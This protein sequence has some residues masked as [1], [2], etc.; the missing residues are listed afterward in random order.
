MF[1]TPNVRFPGRALLGLVLLLAV[2]AALAPRSTLATTAADPN[3]RTM[4]LPPGE[5]GVDVSWPQC[6]SQRLPEDIRSFAIIGVTGGRITSRNDCLAGQYQWAKTAPTPP[7]VY[8][9][10]NS[11]PASYNHFTC[12]KEDA[13]CNS[14]RWGYHNTADVV[15]YARA[16]NSD[17]KVWWL[18]VE[19]GNFWTTNKA[20][21]AEVLRGVITYLR[22]TGH[23]VGIYSTPYQYGIIAG[24][25]APGLPV[26]TAGAAN[27]TTAPRRCTSEYAF[28]GG[29]VALVQ[30]VSEEYDTNYVCT[31]GVLDSL[32]LPHIASGAFD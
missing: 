18:D 10:T 20:A 3:A 23:V 22:E 9:N 16:K 31:Q 28:G 32:F 26:W 4:Y 1:L 8:I 5:T 12:E 15:A 21:N 11:P 6:D 29:S 13:T 2:S 25:Y 19:T 7:Q 30:F 17:A 27:V 14:F 24:T